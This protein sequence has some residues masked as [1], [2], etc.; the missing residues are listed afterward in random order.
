MYGSMIIF[1]VMPAV[2]STEAYIYNKLKEPV[3]HDLKT[4]YD[5]IEETVVKGGW[6]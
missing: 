3:Y 5:Q 6:G 2:I 1:I 4:S